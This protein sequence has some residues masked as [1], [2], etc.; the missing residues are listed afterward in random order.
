MVLLDVRNTRPSIVPQYSLI[1]NLS[2]EK[3]QAALRS[4][5]KWDSIQTDGPSVSSSDP[6]LN[7]EIANAL[8]I[9]AFL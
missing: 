7:K 2:K 3:I 6:T 8:Y 4:T 1:S 9:Y 5:W